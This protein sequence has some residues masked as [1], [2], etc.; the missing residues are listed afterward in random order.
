MKLIDNALPDSPPHKY[1]SDKISTANK[2]V[3]ALVPYVTAQLNA[4]QANELKTFVIGDGM[5]YGDSL[6]KNMLQKVKRF[7]RQLD[8]NG[9][10]GNRNRRNDESSKV[11]KFYNRPLDGNSIYTAFQRTFIDEVGVLC[12]YS[13]SSLIT[14][15]E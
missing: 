4:D 14:L 7:A 9:V 10:R 6:T 2:T 3:P 11:M 15:D 1:T 12:P 5:N 13:K 8:R